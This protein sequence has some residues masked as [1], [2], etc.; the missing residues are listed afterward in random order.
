MLVAATCAGAVSTGCGAAPP[1]AHVVFWAQSAEQWSI[2]HSSHGVRLA[3]QWDT[4]FAWTD[5]RE[6][7]FYSEQQYCQQSHIL[8]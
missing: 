6:T 3:A 8:P 7:H 4:A 1:G 5:S 2:P